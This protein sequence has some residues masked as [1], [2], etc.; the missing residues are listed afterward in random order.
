VH[1]SE[2]L[3]DYHSVHKFEAAR[4]FAPCLWEDV[5]RIVKRI[6]FWLFALAG[7]ILVAVVLAVGERS[8]MAGRAIP[9]LAVA[10]MILAIVWMLKTI[11]QRVRD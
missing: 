6:E 10:W 5:M 2:L 1:K 7:S 8:S 4:L 3:I 11:V 9:Y